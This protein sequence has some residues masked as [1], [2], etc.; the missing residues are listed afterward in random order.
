MPRTNVPIIAV[1]LGATPARWDIGAAGSTCLSATVVCISSLGFIAPLTFFFKTIQWLPEPHSYSNP[2]L[3]NHT[4]SSTTHF[5]DNLFIKN[6]HPNNVNVVS[7]GERLA[8][9]F[10][11]M[12]GEVHY[13][14]Y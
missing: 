12:C 3:K 4:S 11:P 13:A 6:I 2:L 14:T 1:H 10:L 7:H 8:S 5:Y 9:H